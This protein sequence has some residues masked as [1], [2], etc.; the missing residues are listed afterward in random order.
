MPMLLEDLAE[1]TS[2]SNRRAADR[3][4]A[5]A[6]DL[7][8]SRRSTTA[9]EEVQRKAV[10]SAR[11]AA[12]YAVSRLSQAE[13]VWRMALASLR[14][15]PTGDAAERLL[16]IHLEGFYSGRRL[17]HAARALWEIPEQMGAAKERHDE[18]DRA[19]ARFEELANEAEKAL[20]HRTRGWQP[21]DPDRLALGLRLAREG[22]TV[23]A[24][25]ARTWFRQTPG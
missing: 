21:A 12:D 17:A 15:K 11:Q 19:H 5:E 10:E 7:E 20:E 25:E 14:Q 8:E 2:A 3:L 22:K 13:E 9:P 1:E 6:R 23:K 16:R 18:L 24:D 4:D